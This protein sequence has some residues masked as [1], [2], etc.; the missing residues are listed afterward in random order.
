MYSRHSG[1]RFS[2]LTVGTWGLAS[3][4]GGCFSTVKSLLGGSVD[5]CVFRKPQSSINRVSLQIVL[6][7]EQSGR[8]EPPLVKACR[9]GRLEVVHLLLEAG[10]DRNKVGNSTPL[11][12]ACEA[13]KVDIVSTLVADGLDTE[14]FG[15]LA[16][17]C[18]HGKE[19]I[20]RVLLHARANPDGAYGLSTSMVPLAEASR[21]GSVEAARL[22]LEGRADTE[23]RTSNDRQT[24]LGIAAREGKA[25]IVQL[26]FPDSP[27]K[28]FCFIVP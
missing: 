14:R 22:L 21:K 24:A 5:A 11:A 16:N 13:G 28:L 23:R 18:T 7:R 26:L 2:V 15:P 3:K 19:E 25:E 4:K 17:A 20:V 1:T 6:G 10:A 8:R 12:A 9:Y 27:Q